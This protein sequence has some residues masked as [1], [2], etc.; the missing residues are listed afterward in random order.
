[1]PQLLRIKLRETGTLRLMPKMLALMAVQRQRA[2]SRSARPSR[3]EQHGFVG[4]DPMEIPM[5]LN[6]LAHT[7]NLRASLGQV[8]LGGLGVG[9]YGGGGHAG[10]G[11]G[12]GFGGFGFGQSPQALTRV[13]KIMLK[14]RKRA[15]VVVV[16]E[17]IFS[18]PSCRFL[19]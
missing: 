15:R 10:G 2:A 16:L 13:K 8:S 18:N 6:T 17:P 5:I 11:F 4:G 9:E 14:A 1:M 12:F 3:S 19:V 7:P